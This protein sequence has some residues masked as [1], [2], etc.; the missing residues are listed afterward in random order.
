M[1]NKK[2]I[3]GILLICVCFGA[4]VLSDIAYQK[5]GG[6]VKQNFENNIYSIPEYSGTAYVEVNNNKAFFKKEEITTEVFENYADLDSYGRC[7]VAYANV[8][9]EQMPMEERGEIGMIRPSGW[10]TVKYPEVIE[11]LI[12]T[13]DNK[14]NFVGQKQQIAILICDIRGF[15]TI[16]EYNEPENVVSFL[17]KYFT[18]SGMPVASSQYW[19]M[20]HGNSPEEVK[21]D[22]EGMQTMRTLGRNM[23]FLIKSIQL[24]KEQFG[25]PEREKGQYTNFIR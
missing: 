6:I 16:S 9:R 14:T 4:M 22:L 10:H 11:D 23:A 3:I 12:K 24:G 18:I 2:I 19:N 17:N 15:T 8:C 7:G 21:Q 20:V 25:L 5:Q 1:K 13:S